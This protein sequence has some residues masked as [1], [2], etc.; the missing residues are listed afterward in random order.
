MIKE[1]SKGQRC[2]CDATMFLVMIFDW[3]ETKSNI[4]IH[5]DAFQGDG[6]YSNQDKK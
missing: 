1:T 2:Y 3:V 6:K 5:V 4:D